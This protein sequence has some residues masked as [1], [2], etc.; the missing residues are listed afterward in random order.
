[1]LLEA[2][3]GANKGKCF[4][5]SSFD[6]KGHCGDSK[7]MVK[8]VDTDADAVADNRPSNCKSA[9]YFCGYCVTSTKCATFFYADAVVKNTAAVANGHAFASQAA[10]EASCLICAANLFIELTAADNVAGS[11]IASNEV[12]C[13]TA[14]DAFIKVKDEVTTGAAP[15]I[16]K[17]QDAFNFCKAP[18]AASSK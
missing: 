4:I 2:S 13:G 6:T 3:A 12:T 8:E 10:A 16:V 11:C 17:T 7:A 15:S 18:A 9:D 5:L 14:T 1:M